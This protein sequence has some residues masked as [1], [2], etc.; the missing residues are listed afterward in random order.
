[1]TSETQP[2]SENAAKDEYR[3]SNWP[4]YEQALVK[5][6][7]ISVWLDEEFLRT[8]WRAPA[9]GKRG[10][11]FIYSAAT[12][13]TLLVLKAVFGLPYRSLEGFVRSLL[14]L[15]GVDLPVPEHT[16]MLRQAQHK[17]R[18]GLRVCR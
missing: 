4:E 9:S 15:M 14:K 16:Q 6:G 5:R 13:Q 1:M 2:A 12:I 3:I 7:D 18:G 8:G 10:A 17:C 11:P